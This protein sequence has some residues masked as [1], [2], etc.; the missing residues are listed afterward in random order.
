MNNNKIPNEV[1]DG[2]N[3]ACGNIDWFDGAAY[4]DWAAL[5]PMTELEFEKACRGPEVPVPSDYAWNSK[6]I[7]LEEYTLEN[8]GA[9]N[10]RVQNPGTGTFGNCSHDL[11]TGHHSVLDSPLR[12][13][14]F[15]TETSTRTYS[16]AS[17]YG[18]MEL[19]GNIQE[20]T[21]AFG[22]PEG[23]T[24]RGTNGDGVLTESGNAT[25]LDWPGIV[26]GEEADGVKITLGSGNRGGDWNDGRSF[27]HIASR[28]WS[29]FD[30]FGRN[31]GAGYRCVRSAE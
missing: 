8:A 10:E 21:V 18:I 2:Q 28:L 23:R 19:T 4:S 24:Y 13:G 30:P 7:V 12:V 5:R 3:I 9:E 27:V 25:N 16:G 22:I 1:N 29:S 17:Y 11:T 20:R 31:I 6:I 15:A 14:I 26:Q